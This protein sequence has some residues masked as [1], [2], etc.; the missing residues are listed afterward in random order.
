[1]IRCNQCAP[2]DIY[3]AR[4]LHSSF[5]LCSFHWIKKVK[6]TH[7]HTFI[8][9]TLNNITFSPNVLVWLDSSSLNT[10]IL[11]ASTP[12]KPFFNT[13]K[14]KKNLCQKPTTCIYLQDLSL[15]RPVSRMRQSLWD[16]VSW[17]PA[18]LIYPIAASVMWLA[19]FFC[20]KSSKRNVTRMMALICKSRRLIHCVCQCMWPT[21]WRWV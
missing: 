7:T 2:A 17:F 12:G 1:M 9:I 21:I 15:F 13:K 3:R 8:Y 11:L 10:S 19:L 20:H 16:T 4:M 18:T 14:K 6:R 5:L